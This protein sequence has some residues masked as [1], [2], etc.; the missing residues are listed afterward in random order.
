[1]SSDHFEELGVGILSVPVSLILVF[2][3]L[4][5]IFFKEK[6]FDNS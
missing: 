6:I 4:A 1:M 5:W 2:T 3:I